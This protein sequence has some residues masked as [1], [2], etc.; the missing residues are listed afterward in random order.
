MGYFKCIK[1][2][3]LTRLHTPYVIIMRITLSVHSL[4]QQCLLSLEY[5]SGTILCAGDAAITKP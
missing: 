5:I 3:V 1:E 4:N 2:S